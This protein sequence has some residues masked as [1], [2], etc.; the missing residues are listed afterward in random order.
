MSQG[1]FLGVFFFLAEYLKF[2]TWSRARTCLTGIGSTIVAINT[3]KMFLGNKLLFPNTSEKYNFSCLQSN[4]DG[5]LFLA[6]LSLC[7]MC[8]NT[9]FAGKYGP[10]KTPYL[11]TFHAVYRHT[12]YDFGYK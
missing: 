5:T 11:D 4:S 10:E 7:E 9:E 8:P 2:E 6:T 1:F 12:N 3:L